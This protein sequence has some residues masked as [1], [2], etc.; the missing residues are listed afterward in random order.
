MPFFH[1]SCGLAAA[2]WNGNSTLRPV[3]ADATAV[4]HVRNLSRLGYGGLLLVAV[5]LPLLVTAPSQARDREITLTI[6]PD[7]TPGLVRWRI[8]TAQGGSGTR[9]FAIG[10]YPEA[11]A[12][13]PAPG[14]DAGGPQPVSLPIR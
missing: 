2:V 13:T 9:T 14:Q 3:P 5:V 10:E 1:K 7:A 8:G 4:W 6:A 12:R 11:P